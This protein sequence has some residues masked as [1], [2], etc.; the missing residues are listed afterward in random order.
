[1]K[2]PGEIYMINIFFCVKSC[3]FLCEILPPQS[4]RYG[5]SWRVKLALPPLNTPVWNLVP[6]NFFLFDSYCANLCQTGQDFTFSHRNF[7]LFLCLGSA[8]K[9]SWPLVINFFFNSKKRNII[10]DSTTIKKSRKLDG[11]P[12][13]KCEILPPKTRVP[14]AKNEKKISLI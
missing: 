1:M 10:R 11:R 12:V 6:P 7:F 2:F 8:K 3:P 9:I 13:W 5:E 14:T 4:S